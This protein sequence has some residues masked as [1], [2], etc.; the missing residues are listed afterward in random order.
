M[1]I[2]FYKFFIVKVNGQNYFLDRVDV[3]NTN[4]LQ[5]GWSTCFDTQVPMYE[6]LVSDELRLYIN[7]EPLYELTVR[8]SPCSGKTVRLKICY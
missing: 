5:H 6:Y 4:F 3:I 1:L 2:I 8:Y 7:N